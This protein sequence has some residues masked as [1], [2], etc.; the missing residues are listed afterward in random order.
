MINRFLKYQVLLFVLFPF[1]S[2]AQDSEQL[3]TVELDSV[4]FQSKVKIPAYPYRAE[5]DSLLKVQKELTDSARKKMEE[6]PGLIIDYF[7]AEPELYVELKNGDEINLAEYQKLIKD[8]LPKNLSCLINF[9]VEWDGTI[10]KI[11]LE[12][13]KTPYPKSFDIMKYLSRIK[14]KPAK[15][16]GVILPN[17]HSMSWLIKG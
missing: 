5:Y 9:T 12:R 8:D 17:K 11:K 14:A 10:S 3:E 6:N 4:L 7:P 16:N 2:L 13:C 15:E 1:L